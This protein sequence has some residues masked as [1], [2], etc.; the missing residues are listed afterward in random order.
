MGW[1]ASRASGDDWPQPEIKP[2]RLR[3]NVVV[4]LRRTK[5]PFLPLGGCEQYCDLSGRLSAEGGAAKP[6]KDFET[7]LFDP[8]SV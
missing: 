6:I 2:I 7:T 4:D 1:A 5:S 3:I 8:H